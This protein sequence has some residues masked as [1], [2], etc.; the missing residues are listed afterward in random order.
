ME[1][2]VINEETFEEHSSLHFN[3]G[4]DSYSEQS[5]NESDTTSEF[6]VELPKLQLF[7]FSEENYIKAQIALEREFVDQ[8]SDENEE[9]FDADSKNQEVPL[10]PIP[11]EETN[12]PVYKPNPTVKANFSPCVL[13]DYLDNKLQM[14]G[15]TGNVRNICQLVGTWQ[16]DEDAILR[17]ESKGISL[18]VCMN[19]FNYDQKNHNAY[20]KQLR[21]PEQSEI[22][23]RRCL[24]CFKNFYFF[25]RGAGCKDHLWRIWGKY[26][27][28]P[29]IGLYS[30]NAV[31]ECQD[32]SKR[33]FDDVSTVR[34]ICYNCYES[35]G[36]HLNH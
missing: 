22:C 24:L 13:I 10:P 17:F 15:Q 7:E 33:I 29:C 18:G 11:I 2:C 35:H 21:S 9:D 26:I 36:G 12:E 6:F 4:Q 32:I 23:R 5:D 14:C 25:S 16:I 1:T 3:D 20:I 31:H 28:I 30:C 8:L 27:Q 19:H 34:Y